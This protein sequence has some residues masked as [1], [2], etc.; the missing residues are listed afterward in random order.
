[1]NALTE[2]VQTIMENGKP[3]FAV[4]PYEN[5]KV[6]CR[7]LDSLEL[8]PDEV[9]HEVAA[10][11]LEKSYSMSKAWRIYLRMNQ[12]EAAQKIGIS[13][14]ALSQIE[15]SET[16]HRQT[17]QKIADAYGIHINQLDI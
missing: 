15:K 14:A 7:R 8:E 6:I 13:Q 2:N 17:L 1:M 12:R 4:I 16:N 10:M 3:A 5:Y 9:P 11:M